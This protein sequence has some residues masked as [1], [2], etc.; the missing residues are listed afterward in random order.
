MRECGP[1]SACC[2][3]LAVN[4]IKKPAW[5]KCK[6]QSESGCG[7]YA[8]QPQPCR[9]Y[10]C[11]WLEGE[12]EEY[13]RPDLIGVII[14]SGATKLFSHTWG[15]DAVTAREIAANTSDFSGSKELIK[16]LLEQDRVVFVKTYGGGSKFL[17]YS[18][19]QR[20]KFS[21]LSKTFQV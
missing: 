4:V 20:K 11:K 3:V 15:N 1:C 6:D 8:E 17:S 21:Q 9:D 18:Q 2:G 7:I 10:K 12:L 5:E 19:E 16:K 14:D 13:E